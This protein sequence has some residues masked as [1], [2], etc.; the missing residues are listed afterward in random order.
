MKAY[1]F[2]R[3]WFISLILFAFSCKQKEKSKKEA[4]FPVLSFIKGQVAE[5]DT[6]LY[7]IRKFTVI[8]TLGGDT[9]SIPREQFR[10][11]AKDFLTIPDLASGEFSDRFTEEKIFDETMNRVLLSYA[12][13]SPEKEEIQ[14]Q[15]VLIKPNP[16]GDQITSIIINRFFNS[17]D[18]TVEKR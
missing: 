13:V 8:D 18:S 15:E 5:I 1:P 11:E 6:S 12:P 2:F 7:H 16:S 9:I 3:I 10:E 4:F 17:K 14:K